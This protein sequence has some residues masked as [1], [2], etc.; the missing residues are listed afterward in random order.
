MR[1]EHMIL[2][3]KVQEVRDGVGFQP[4]QFVERR[5]R[6][7]KLRAAYAL[8]VPERQ[9][10]PDAARVRGVRKAGVVLETRRMRGGLPAGCS[11]GSGNFPE[12]RLETPAGETNLAFGP[13]G[14]AAG[15]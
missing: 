12:T 1:R 7:G 9:E 11:P 8:P 10:G 5:Q 6:G 15:D 2:C 13:D 14:I 3:W 4:D